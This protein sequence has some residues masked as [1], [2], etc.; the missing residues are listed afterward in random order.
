MAAEDLDAFMTNAA[1]GEGN[2]PYELPKAGEEEL[3][4]SWIGAAL[5]HGI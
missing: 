2:A 4:L 1:V 5:A 3:V